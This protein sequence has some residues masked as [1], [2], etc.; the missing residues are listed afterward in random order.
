M[1]AQYVLV[2]IHDGECG[3]H[4][5]GNTLAR[6]VIRVEYYW[7]NAIKNVKEFVKNYVKCQEY[8]PMQHGPP[9][10]LTSITAS[11]L[12]PSGASS[13][14]DYFSKERVR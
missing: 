10:E 6:K 13:W 9:E 8:V 4:S 5:G 1:K 11:S 3:N 2:E 14:L 12:L 7:P